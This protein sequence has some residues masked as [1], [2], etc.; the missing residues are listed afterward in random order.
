MS[1]LSIVGITAIF[2]TTVMAISFCQ[3][4]FHFTYLPSLDIYPTRISN[5]LTGLIIA[6][7]VAIAALLMH[8][9]IT[10]KIPAS[11]NLA[12]FCAGVFVLYMLVAF[13]LDFIVAEITD[14]LP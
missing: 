10:E 5:W 1:F 14:S 13:V 12:K 7:D 8:W 2:V 4:L 9:I 3:T 11:H 6:G